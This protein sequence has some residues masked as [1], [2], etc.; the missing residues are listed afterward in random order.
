LRSAGRGECSKR[1]NGEKVKGK[2]N[3]LHD[4]AAIVCKEYLWNG[5][6]HKNLNAKQADA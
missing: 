2:E 3:D 6:Y 1:S 4:G 5:W